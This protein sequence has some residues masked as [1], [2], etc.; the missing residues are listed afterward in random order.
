MSG[1]GENIKTWRQ[2]KIIILFLC[3]HKMKAVNDSCVVS[4]IKYICNVRCHF[5]A[6]SNQPMLFTI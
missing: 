4:H 1:D 6:T 5:S 3:V 2:T